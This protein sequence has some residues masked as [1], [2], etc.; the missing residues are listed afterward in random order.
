MMYNFYCNIDESIVILIKVILQMFPSLPTTLNRLKS[1][2]KYSH[3]LG[4]QDPF[5]KFL[6]AGPQSPPLVNFC[7]PIFFKAP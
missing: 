7:V 3:F 6:E 2:K 5:G 4:G 1:I